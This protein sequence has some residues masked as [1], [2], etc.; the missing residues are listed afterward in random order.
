MSE[1]CLDDSTTGREHGTSTTSRFLHLGNPAEAAPPW[2]SGSFRV[3]AAPAAS[4]EKPTMVSAG[5][6]ERNGVRTVW[7][8]RDYRRLTG[9]HLKH[10]HYFD[11]VRRTP[12]FAPRIVFGDAPPDEGNARERER[13]WPGGEEVLAGRWSPQPRDLLFVAGLDWRYLRQRGLESL[14][15]PRINLVQHVRHAHEGTELYEYLAEW[16][17]RICVS[18]EVADAITAT[19]RTRGPVFAIPNGVDAAPYASSG[20]GPPTGYESRPVPVTVAG[21]KRPDLARA[22]SER[23]LAAGIEHRLLVEFIDR[24]AYLALLA[25]SR[26]AVCLPRE[27]EGFYLPALEA[28]AL[29]CLAVTLDCIGNRGFCH[30]H[31]NC[32]IAE[33]NPDSLFRAV[34]RA[35]A[36]TLSE[37]GRML[38]RGRDTAARH[39]L[40]LERRR[41][42]AILGD[43][44]RLW[45]TA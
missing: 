15:N 40:G 30:D 2:V 23:L 18:R 26:V 33:P 9:G 16:A 27:K 4:D 44:D 32:I 28:M 39:S 45:R 35:L 21:Y 43:I 37:C 29:G 25:E 22:L 10:S 6:A 36:M 12:E 17:V 19:G 34:E 3:T 41:F 11:H 13:L 8:H 24:E 1:R 14:P 42:H 5:P 38:E 7:F 31:W 20:N